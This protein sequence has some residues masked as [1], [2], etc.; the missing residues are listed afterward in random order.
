M[1]TAFT[2]QCLFNVST[3]Y[4]GSLYCIS[5]LYTIQILLEELNIISSRQKKK[6]EEENSACQAGI[7][8]L[9]C[10]Q[11]FYMTELCWISFFFFF[12]TSP[13]ASYENL[14]SKDS[15]SAANSAPAQ[16]EGFAEPQCSS[17]NDL[18]KHHTL[19]T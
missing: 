5:R 7:S 10:T 4:F 17:A 3:I 6:K 19:A 9:L 18:R 11:L 15:F 12:Y 13:T 2:M 16:H 8:C 14:T 1:N